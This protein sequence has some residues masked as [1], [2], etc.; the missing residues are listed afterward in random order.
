MSR[1]LSSWNSRGGTLG[2]GEDL[3]GDVGPT[4]AHC[5]LIL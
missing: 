1:K 4:F 5:K 3:L 2:E